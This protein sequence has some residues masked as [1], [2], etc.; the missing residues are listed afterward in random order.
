MAKRSKARLGVLTI[1]PRG[2][3]LRPLPPRKGGGGAHR[4][5]ELSDAKALAIMVELA[6]LSARVDL[7]AHSIG[8][9]FDLPPGAF[10]EALKKRRAEFFEKIKT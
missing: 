4:M 3:T 9:M 2:A 6:E 10:G 7:L 5:R 1:G 8:L